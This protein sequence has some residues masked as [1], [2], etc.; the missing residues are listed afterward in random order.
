MTALTTRETKAL[1]RCEQ[2]IQRGLSTFCDVGRALLEIRDGRLYRDMHDTFESY[3]RARWEMSKTHANRLIGAAAV[4]DA[5]API[6]VKPTTESQV[7]PLTTVPEESRAA[8]WQDAVEAAPVDADGTP[9][10]TARHVEEAVQRW[11]G[12]PEEASEPEATTTRCRCCGEMVEPDEDRDCP[13]CHEPSVDETPMVEEG[14][15]L[16]ERPLW[17]QHVERLAREAVD[18]EGAAS[19]AERLQWLADEILMG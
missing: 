10:V 5:V 16:E 9:R 17:I 7:R 3:C 12:E 8:V 15:P 11:R 18:H 13:R 6:G 1:A 19:V 2:T 14:T 4:A